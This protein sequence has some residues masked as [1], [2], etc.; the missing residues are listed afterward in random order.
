[1]LRR[2]RN[3]GQLAIDRREEP[4]RQDASRQRTQWS[5][6]PLPFLLLVVGILWLKISPPAKDNIRTTTPLRKMQSIG[7]DKDLFDCHTANATCHLFRPLEFFAEN[8]PGHRYLSM[9]EEMGGE[10]PNLPRMTHFHWSSRGSK[11]QLAAENI[12]EKDPH[13]LLHYLP[14]DVTFFHMR[15]TGGTSLHHAIGHLSK[16]IQQKGART[17]VKRYIPCPGFLRKKCENEALAHMRKVKRDQDGNRNHVVFA[18]VR[19]PVSRFL[20]AV[21]QAMD[22]TIPTGQRLRQTC[23]D[24][25]SIQKTIRCVLQHL[26]E[27]GVKTDVHFCP[28]AMNLFVLMR[29][30]NVQVALFETHHFPKILKFFGSSGM[31]MRDRSIQDYLKSALLAKMS[32]QDLDSESIRVICQLYAVDVEML[33]Y[34]GLDVPLCST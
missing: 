11:M 12:S 14:P 15:K 5:K 8:H 2:R 16:F 24:E 3:V 32:V 34:V 20:S 33:K 1:M 18:V 22:D 30:I 26:K 31:H 28:M 19:D 29:G 13:P 25:S 4:A 9:L 21:G 23:L 7:T 6:A 17:K 10:L 27:K